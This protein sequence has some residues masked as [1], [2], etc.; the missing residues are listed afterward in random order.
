MD[1]FFRINYNEK[2]AI[3]AYCNV[4]NKLKKVFDELNEKEKVVMID[5]IGDEEV[6]K[7]ILFNRGNIRY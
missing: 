6:K 7:L 3:K 4:L 2:E 5:L 1:D